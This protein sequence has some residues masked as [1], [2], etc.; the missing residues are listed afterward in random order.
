MQVAILCF[1]DFWFSAEDLK[2]LLQ[3]ATNRSRGYSQA[4]EE[5]RSASHKII[6]VY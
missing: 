5:V 4:I 2:W 6:K 1:V 3:H